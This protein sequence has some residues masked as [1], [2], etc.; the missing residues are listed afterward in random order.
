MN[1]EDT[2]TIYSFPINTIK[3]LMGYFTNDCDTF[4]KRYRIFRGRLVE[5]GNN[6][7]IA[8]DIILS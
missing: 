5:E 4:T 3:K 2:H 7:F 8:K 1:T 6:D